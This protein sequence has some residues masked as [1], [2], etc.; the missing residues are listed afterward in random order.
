MAVRAS[1][2]A[3][4][5]DGDARRYFNLNQIWAAIFFS[6]NFAQARHW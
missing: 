3:F 4:R 1:N 5:I 2:R 6:G